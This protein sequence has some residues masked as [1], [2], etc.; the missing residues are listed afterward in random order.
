MGA[1]IFPEMPFSKNNLV[2]VFNL[3]EDRV[4]K[5]RGPR[6][7]LREQARNNINI[8]CVQLTPDIFFYI[9]G[10]RKKYNCQNNSHSL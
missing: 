5:K 4:N 7:K 2:S 6:G 9:V 10:K 3:T 1:E 8:N